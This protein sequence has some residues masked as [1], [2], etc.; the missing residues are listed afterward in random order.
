MR[1]ADL[2]AQYRKSLNPPY[3][4]KDLTAILA[5]VF[6]L[7]ILPLTVIAGL[8]ARSLFPQAKTTKDVPVAKAGEPTFISNELLIKVKKGSRNKV[9]VGSPTNMGIS[10][11]NK[12]N[13]EFRVKK[14]SQVAKVGKK[15]KRKA[16][17]FAWYKVNLPGKGEKVSGKLEK[18]VLKLTEKNNSNPVVETLQQLIFKLSKD[19]NIAVIEPNY[20]VSI[21]PAATDPAKPTSTPE[22]ATTE[23]VT[24]AA[25]PNDPYYSSSGSWGQDYQDL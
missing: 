13:K 14:F 3:T 23:Q 12:I 16:E 5:T 4:S 6:V 20:V 11:I 22:P 19:P 15:S 8:Q 25:T 2:L 24:P 1:A 10:S 17:I 21:L 9:K 18:T 7:V